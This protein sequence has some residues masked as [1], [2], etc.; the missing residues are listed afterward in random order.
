M[1]LRGRAFLCSK[2]QRTR[3]KGTWV[4]TSSSPESEPDFL[5]MDPVQ[6]LVDQSASP[7]A[8][9]HLPANFVSPKSSP[10]VTSGQGQE[11]SQQSSLEHFGL[12]DAPIILEPQQAGDTA[13]IAS[14]DTALLSTIAP[15]PLPPALLNYTFPSFTVS[16]FGRTTEESRDYSPSSHIPPIRPPENGDGLPTREFQWL[17]QKRYSCDVPSLASLSRAVSYPV[18]FEDDELGT[19]LSELDLGLELEKAEDLLQTAMI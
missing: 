19:F 3:I 7:P 15:L 13:P 10:L 2:I 5:S 11:Y 9:T 18:F 6:D 4:R 16:S 14:T 17:H 12:L 1:F 8:T